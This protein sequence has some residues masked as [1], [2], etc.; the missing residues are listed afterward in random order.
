MKPVSP[1]GSTSP[2]AR[3]KITFNYP[4]SPL[5]EKPL[6]ENFMPNCQLHAI[7]TCSRPSLKLRAQPS[8]Y[9]SKK[10]TTCLVCNKQVKYTQCRPPIK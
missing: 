3:P 5:K 1:I 7:D 10:E 8:Q 9:I 4:I 6:N 2:L